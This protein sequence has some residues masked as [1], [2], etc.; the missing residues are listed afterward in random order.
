MSGIVI[1]V[2]PEFVSWR[3]RTAL[4][5]VDYL[6]DFDWNDRDSTWLLAMRKADG[7]LLRAGAVIDVIRPL[8]PSPTLDMPQGIMVAIDLSGDSTRPGLN[9]LGTRVLLKYYSVGQYE[10][11]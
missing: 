7:T 3:Q 9:D 10:A 4:D 1:P 8:L 2:T 5:G 11:L 6:L